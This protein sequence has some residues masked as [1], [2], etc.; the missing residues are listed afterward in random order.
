MTTAGFRRPRRPLTIGFL[1]DAVGDSYQ[2]EI[3]QGSLEAAHDRGAQLLC[4]EGGAFHADANPDGPPGAP[5]SSAG[6][7]SLI[8]SQAIDG[9]VVMAGA[10]GNEVGAEALRTTCERFRPLPMC[11][12]ALDVPGFSSVTV[13]N[14]I[15]A[16]EVLGHLVVHHGM[17]RVAFVRGPEANAEA[18]RRFAAYREVLAGASVPFDPA[19]VA[20]GDF[21]PE[22]GRRA[23]SLLLDE[24]AKQ[25]A[26]L[27]AI[28]CANDAMAL[29]VLEALERRG[30]KVPE[31]LAL[32]GFDDVA[33]SRFTTP[34]LTTVRQPLRRQGREAVRMVLAQDERVETLVLGTELCV[35]HS[36]GCVSRRAA[37][38]PASQPSALGMEAMLVQRREIMV[39]DL[40]RA[41]RGAFAAAGPGWEARLVAAFTA[42]LAVRSRGPVPVAP[43]LPVGIAGTGSVRPPPAGFVETYD[44][45]LRRL[46]AA[47]IDPAICYDV[48]A[49]LRRH[50]LRCV[51]VDRREQA[52]AEGL[53]EQIG[54]LTGA[55]MERVQAWQRIDA[56]HRA[57]V[58]GRAGAAMAAV[59]E[60]G[61]VARA[62]STYLPS[63]G[64]ERCYLVAIAPPRPAATRMAR[65]TFAYEAAVGGVI[66]HQDDAT[67]RADE[68]LPY[69]FMGVAGR[70]R[71]YAVAEIWSRG[72]EMVLLVL[73]LAQP[74]GHVYEA[75]RHL[76]AAAV[77]GARVT[78]LLAEAR[79]RVAA[80]RDALLAASNGQDH[81]P[82][83]L[84]AALEAARQGLDRILGPARSDATKG[85]SPSVRPS[86]RR[87]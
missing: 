69:A 46:V 53:L 16:R 13:D 5:Q 65:L 9:L 43:S 38:T 11:F 52:L 30:I 81:E 40:A 21:T 57:N 48:V 62:S 31:Q 68:I 37:A 20:P 79:T 59:F 26:D 8:S 12:V 50:V 44:E 28:A 29:G 25:V 75:L 14:G 83:A 84:E 45:I 70:E 56:Q 22:A 85:T 60:D 47:G 64:V 51:G 73:D 49:T 87:R 4:F 42:E 18:E 86:S 17:R 63:L 7:L 41:A 15:G 82:K 23:V 35:R 36:C 61:D 33:E 77:E 58:L 54:E 78:N 6:L 1:V 34:S 72:G 67:Y 71:G 39:A 76:F 66:E 80:I 55:V 24:R 3:L 19:L 2:W 10:I 32:V 27:E 74:E